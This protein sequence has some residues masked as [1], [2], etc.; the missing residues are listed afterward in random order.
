MDGWMQV[1]VVVQT[2]G[3][4]YLRGRDRRITVQGQLRQKLAGDPI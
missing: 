3:L 1:G 4:S 2:Y